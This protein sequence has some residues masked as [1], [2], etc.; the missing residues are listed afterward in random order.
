MA[1][2]VPL[3]SPLPRAGRPSLPAAV[4]QGRII[5]ANIRKFIHYLFS[6]NLSEIVVMLLA[7]LLGQPLPLLPLQI[8]WLNLVT[9]VFPALS[10]A[11]EP[12]E[13][14]IMERPPRSPDAALLGRRTVRSILGYAVLIAVSALTAFLLGRYVCKHPEPTQMGGVDAAVTMSFLTIGLGQL[15]HVFNSRK[16]HGALKAHEWLSNRYV[17]GA[18]V[19]TVALQLCAVYLPGLNTVLKTALLDG[20]DWLIVGVCSLVP[21]AAGQLSARFMPSGEP[22]VNAD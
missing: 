20:R 11:M 19:L 1:Q 7:S 6:C 16:E 22:G 3:L 5:Y 2:R 17:L 14:D 10:L 9:D 15:F 18:V 8:L 4:R 21:M 13:V 12:G